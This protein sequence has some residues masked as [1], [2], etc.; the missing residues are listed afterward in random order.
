MATMLTS[1]TQNSATSN[2]GS[3]PPLPNYIF[4]MVFANRGLASEGQI[5]QIVETFFDLTGKKCEYEIN[6][7][8]NGFTYI[9]FEDPEI[10]EMFLKGEKLTISRS[11]DDPEWQAPSVPLEEAKEKLVEEFNWSDDEEEMNFENPINWSDGKENASDSPDVQKSLSSSATPDWAEAADPLTLAEKIE[12]LEYS[13]QCPKVE[14]EEQVGNF[15]RFQYSPEQLIRAREDAVKMGDR[16]PIPSHGSITVEPV[17]AWS[18][19][20]RPCIHNIVINTMIPKG[21][22]EQ[23]IRRLMGKF[24]TTKTLHMKTRDGPREVPSPHIH[25]IRGRGFDQIIV[26][27]H[28][29]THDAHTAWQMRAYY[30]GFQLESG[31]RANF[32]FKRK[33]LKE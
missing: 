26:T 27:Y 33:F 21:T 18:P 23:D 24:A 3:I 4:R 17:E 11:I 28:P 31:E 32:A 30:T 10:A 14:V 13:Y 22:T 25:F 2:I 8:R 6:Y 12:Q 16:R 15:L 5:K 7:T 29:E 19:N 20:D 1:S 9:W